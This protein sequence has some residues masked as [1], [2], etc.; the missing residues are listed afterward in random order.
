MEHIASCNSSYWSLVPFPKWW[1]R[2]PKK[3]LRWHTMSIQTYQTQ[4]TWFRV[5]TLALSTM[6][7]VETNLLASQSC[8]PKRSSFVSKV[9][10][11][12]CTSSDGF[13]QQGCFSLAVNIRC[14]SISGVLTFV[15]GNV[16]FLF[17]T[18]LVWWNEGIRQWNLLAIPDS[19]E[20]LDQSKTST[21]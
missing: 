19:M 16:S 14:V 17:R 11:G 6:Q 8:P 4:R 1:F 9:F 5:C 10:F 20:R 13:E 15:C 21:L 7:V 2:H 3:N 12:A 18:R